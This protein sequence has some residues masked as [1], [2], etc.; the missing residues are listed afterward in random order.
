MVIYGY[1][2]HSTIVESFSDTK[3]PTGPRSLAGGRQPGSP[4]AVFS[5]SCLRNICSVQIM[6]TIATKAKV[7]KRR[8]ICLKGQREGNGLWPCGLSC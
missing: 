6:L 2:T 8:N 7:K 3:R 5:S 1:L 4:V